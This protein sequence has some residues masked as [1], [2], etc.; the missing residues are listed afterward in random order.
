MNGVQSYNFSRTL[1]L[2]ESSIC[3]QKQDGKKEGK[4]KNGMF[5]KI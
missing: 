4:M 1:E 5:F 2:Y 3:H